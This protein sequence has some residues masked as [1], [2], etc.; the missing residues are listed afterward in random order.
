MEILVAILVLGVIVFIHE[1]GHFMTAKFFRM[2][3]SEFSIGMG[4]QIYSYTTEKT[5]YSIRAIPVGG[6]VN[7]EGMEVDSKLEDGF[8]SKPAYARFVVLFAGVFMNFLLAFGILFFSI[9]GKNIEIPRETTRVG[10]FYEQGIAKNYL[11]I[12]DKILKIEDEDIEKW[13]DIQLVLKKYTSAKDNVKL[14]IEREGKNVE[15][16]VPLT[17][18]GENNE[19]ILGILPETIEKKVGILEAIDLS[20]KNGVR[21]FVETISGLKM[22]LTGKVKANEVSGPIGIIKVVGEASK[23]GMQSVVMLMALLSINVGAL[24]LLPFPAL[25]GG[26][27]IFILLEMVGIRVNKKLE[28]KFHFIGMIVL[29]GAIIFI[30]FNDIINLK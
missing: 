20:I 14:L 25:D 3:V 1:L 26:R 7:I 22:L 29:F 4:P 24:N 5:V 30:T 13:G 11:K 21:F 6:Y 28:E 17:K 8:N 2:P 19:K 23:M 18:V 10:S 9:V 27:I 16:D 15:I 12:E